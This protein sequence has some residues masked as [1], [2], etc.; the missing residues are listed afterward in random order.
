MSHCHT[1]HTFMESP[2]L[3]KHLCPFEVFGRIDTNSLN[4]GQTHFDAV[5]VLQPA[6]PVRDFQP[7]RASS[8]A[9]A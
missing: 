8:E 3:Q 4:V 9:D 2:L 6:Q 5:T 7:V 1:Y